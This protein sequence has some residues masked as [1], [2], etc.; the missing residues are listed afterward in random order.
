MERMVVAA[1]VRWARWAR[2]ISCR[3]AGEV[4][5]SAVKMELPGSTGGWSFKT[6]PASKDEL[7][8]LAR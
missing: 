7:G 5:D 1:G 2:C 4:A 3:K 6:F 8:T